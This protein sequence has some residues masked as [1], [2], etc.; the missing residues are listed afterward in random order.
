ML[1][2]VSSMQE[3]FR[4]ALG[5][6]LAK[7]SHCV[8]EA[9]QAYVVSLLAEFARS[10]NVYAGLKQGEQP[11][12][13]LLLH[14]ARDAEKP[15]A[16][17]KLKH[18]G[19]SSLYLLG[20]FND[21]RTRQH[22]GSR[23]YVAMGENAYSSAANL[24]RDLLT[25]SSEVF[26]ELSV[27][28]AD[29]VAVLQAMRQQVPGDQNSDEQLILLLEHYKKTGDAEALGVLQKHGLLGNALFSAEATLAQKK[30]VIQ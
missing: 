11:A 6:A 7:T 16:I 1:I 21:S 27:R 29:L 22:L 17:R 23:Y 4:E 14:E 12:L 10:E 28:F 15:E 19:D 18:L 26:G 2:A 13:A 25:S 24:A 8:T 3:F 20:F 5:R 9:A 30:L